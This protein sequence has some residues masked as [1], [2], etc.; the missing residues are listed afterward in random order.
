MEPRRLGFE[1][2]AS[3]LRLPSDYAEADFARLP[4][5]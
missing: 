2:G 5:R 4:Y 3:S 1:I